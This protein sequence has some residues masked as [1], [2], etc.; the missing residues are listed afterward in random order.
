MLHAARQLPSWLTYNVSQGMRFAI[1]S[2]FLVGLASTSGCHGIFSSREGGAIRVILAGDVLPSGEMVLKSTSLV[3]LLRSGRLAIGLLATHV[4][5]ERRD[6]TVWDGMEL[7]DSS[8]DIRLRE[9][10]TL[11]FVYAHKGANQ[12]PEPTSGSVTPRATVVISE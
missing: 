3:H 12:S 6:T 4:I 11:R 8:R 7:R 9:G 2:F 5:V 1:L 10:D